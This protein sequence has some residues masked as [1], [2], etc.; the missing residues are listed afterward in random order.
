[1]QTNNSRKLH[2]ERIEKIFEEFTKVNSFSKSLIKYGTLA[3]LVLLGI[4]TILLILNQTVLDF[5]SYIKFIGTS[6]VKNS[7]VVLAEFIIGG[8]V[9]DYFTKR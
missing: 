3:A 5:D 4:G 8:L 7:I 9:I 2:S 1:M 6:I